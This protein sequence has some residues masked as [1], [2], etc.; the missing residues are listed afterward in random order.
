MLL[1]VRWRKTGGPRSLFL[2]G[3]SR[4][5]LVVGRG[6][7]NGPRR[8]GRK[9]KR[10]RVCVLARPVFRPMLLAVCRYYGTVFRK[11]LGEGD[12]VVEERGIYACR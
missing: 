9:R 3:M 4:A 7:G 8:E 10:V 1:V 12:T 6:M 11:C 5:E 2:R